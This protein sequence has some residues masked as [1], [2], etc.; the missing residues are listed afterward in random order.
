MF[1]KFKRFKILEIKIK[2]ALQKAFMRQHLSFPEAGALGF[3]P[4]A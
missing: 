2:T 4:E 3:S 1:H